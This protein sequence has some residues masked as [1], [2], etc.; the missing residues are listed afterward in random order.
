MGNGD[1][2]TRAT[3]H[4]TRGWHAENYAQARLRRIV[5]YHLI[6]ASH[7]GDNQQRVRGWNMPPTTYR[8]ASSR[9]RISLRRRA[10]SAHTTLQAV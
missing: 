1:G 9:L 6:R 7:R 3:G 5:P 2:I 10:P 8:P 4:I